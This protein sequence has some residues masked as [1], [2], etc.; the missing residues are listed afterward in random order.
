MV[1]ANPEIQKLKN[2]KEKAERERRIIARERLRIK[3]EKEA[4]E[5]EIIEKKIAQNQFPDKGIKM[6]EWLEFGNG[7]GLDSR[8]GLVWMTSDF[9]N[10]KGRAPKDFWE[11]KRWV[12]EI[13]RKKFAG[14]DD[15]RIPNIDEYQTIYNTSR[16]KKGRIINKRDS[17]LLRFMP[18]KPVGYPSIFDDSGG[19]WYWTVV[20]DHS[21]YCRQ[22][23]RR[24]CYKIFDFRNGNSGVRPVSV[25][26]GIY[27]SVRLVRG[28]P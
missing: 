15:W 7:T 27:S 6:G 19:Y 5:K 14:F 18:S 10:L 26:D 11:A 23:G 20:P 4:L 3:K 13:N 2:L 28:G 21:N 25:L 16:Q 1:D 24:S 22:I 17:V 12:D 9:T 8:T